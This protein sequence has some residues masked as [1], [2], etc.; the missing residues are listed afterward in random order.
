MHPQTKHETGHVQ[1]RVLRK[2]RIGLNSL[3]LSERTADHVLAGT[4]SSSPKFNFLRR[5]IQRPGP[6][7]RYTRGE[8]KRV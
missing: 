3:Q 1:F 5:E 8:V 4:L 2:I 6:F 7:E